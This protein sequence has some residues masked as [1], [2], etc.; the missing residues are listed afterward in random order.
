[1]EIQNKSE[2]LFEEYLDANGFCGR[3]TYEPSIQGKNKRPDYLLD[4][5]GQK[6][7]FEVK[8][9]RKKDNEPTTRAAHI[10]PYTGL[11][12]E[13]N[14]ARKQFRECK[15]YC[16]S[17]VGPAAHIDPYTSLRKEIDEARKQFKEYKEYCCS[18]VVFNI[19]DRQAKLVP[20]NIMGVMMGNLGFSMD[21]NAEK[22]EVDTGSFKNMFLDGGKMI[23]D[24][25][26][27]PQ[28]TTISSIV[29]LE[30]FH[31]NSEIQKAI[32]EEV[33][34][35]GKPLTNVEE[36]E[37][38]KNCYRSH[39]TS[40][41]VLKVVVVENPWARIAFPEDLFVGPFDEHWRWTEE[42]KKLE[43]IFV[44]NKSKKLE[45]LKHKS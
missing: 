33:K 17:L 18:L 1:M 22:G 3:W 40:S 42:N 15:E 6:Y 45:N 23:D 34:K 7:F 10:D 38:I 39:V 44:G 11:R 26:Q 25:R 8:E 28:N 12:E 29:V 21:Y 30:E 16:C 5:C 14:E 41:R 24:K 32:R 19:G 20:H 13:I 2:K 31:D 35:Q 4:H 37:F 43:R 36:N 27:R 9:L